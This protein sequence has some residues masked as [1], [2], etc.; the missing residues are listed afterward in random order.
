[1]P[2]LYATETVV[3]HRDNGESYFLC[4]ETSAQET[5]TDHR[6]EL[7]R[8]CVTEYGRCVGRSYVDTDQGAK[9]V[10]WVFQARRPF[11]DDASQSSII[12]T[13]VSVYSDDQGTYA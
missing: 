10:G 13:W 9:P 1:M 7:F 6:G 5:F 4:D 11:E 8:F 2:N 3:T 12:E